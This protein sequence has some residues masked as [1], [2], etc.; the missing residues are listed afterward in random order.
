VSGRVDALAAAAFEL[1]HPVTRTGI[2]P[3]DAALA[4]GSI[5]LSHD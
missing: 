4:L 2:E 1:G 3:L 5:H